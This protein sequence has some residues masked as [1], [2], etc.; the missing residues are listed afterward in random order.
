MV[1]IGSSVVGQH[2][3][4]EVLD[5]QLNLF[6]SDKF[7]HAFAE[8]LSTSKNLRSVRVADFLTLFPYSK[9]ESDLRIKST[10]TSRKIEDIFL[11]EY[12]PVDKAD[13][14]QGKGID[15]NQLGLK[16]YDFSDIASG[17]L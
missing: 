5:E 10:H 9:I 12:I 2:A 7:T 14:L 15:R 1:M 3:L 11:Y 8:L 6:L 13:V 17:L 4:S 16:Y